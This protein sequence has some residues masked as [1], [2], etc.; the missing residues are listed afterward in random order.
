MIEVEQGIRTIKLSNYSMH[1]SKLLVFCQVV[2][3]KTLYFGYT[4]KTIAADVKIHSDMVS[5]VSVS[6][7]LYTNA[8]RTISEYC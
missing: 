3:N 1:H 2:Q 5:I 7:E 4:L 6:G 8:S